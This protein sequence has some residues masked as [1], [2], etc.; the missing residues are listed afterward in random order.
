VLRLEITETFLVEDPDQ[1]LT[2]LGRL[3]ALGVGVK[4][5]DFGSGY[6]SLDY[7][8]RFPFDTI[9][10]DRSFVSRLPASR[11]T[12]EIVRAVIGL[13]RSLG[14]DLVAEGIENRAQLDCLKELGCR[15]GQGYWF[16]RPV[17]LE[18]MRRFLLDW[19]ENQAAALD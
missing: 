5:D 13:A 17:D 14:L 11:E 12:T 3:R 16:S 2:A 8:Q 9:K 19:E 6:S 10:I 18:R 1:A 15:Y 4:L 7:L